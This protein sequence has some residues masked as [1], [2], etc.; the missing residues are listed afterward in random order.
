[1]VDGGNEDVTLGEIGRTLVRI[2]QRLDK[3]GD[4]H[5]TRLRRVEKWVYAVP[6]TL[7]LAAA[8]VIAAITK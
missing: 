1:M 5:E 4:D 6:P 3:L 7:I 2:E 8:S